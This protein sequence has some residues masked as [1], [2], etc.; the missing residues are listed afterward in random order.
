VTRASITDIVWKKRFD[1]TFDDVP[2]AAIHD[3]V[4]KYAYR[5]DV[6]KKWTCF[7]LG[8]HGGLIDAQTREVQKKQQKDY[9]DMLRSLILGEAL[10]KRQV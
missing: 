6:S 3:V 9:L 8:K 5:R 1:R 2:G 4:R 7:D 10:A